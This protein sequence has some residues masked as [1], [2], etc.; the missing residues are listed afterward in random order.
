MGRTEQYIRWFGIPILALIITFLVKHDAEQAFGEKYLITLLFTFIFWN[1]S[2][3]TFLGFRRRFPEFR[4]T[5]Q[6][7]S[8]TIV[9]LLFV[10][11]I[12][13]N[14]IRLIFRLT[15]YE[16]YAQD[17]AIFFEKMGVSILAVLIIGSFYESAFFFDKW[18]QSIQANEA[19]KHQQERIQFEVL[20]NQMS[21]HFLF[22]SLNTLSQ[23]ISE[24]QALASEFS[25]KLSDV[26]RYILQNK[27]KELVPLGVELSFVKDYIYLMKMR[28]PENLFVN[29]SVEAV[30]Y[31]FSIAP[32]TLQILIENAVKH[33]V[34]SRAKPL[35][36]DVYTEN[37]KTILVKNNL[38]LKNK[39][40][41]S[42]QTGL[43]NIKKRYEY[44]G[45]E[46]VDVIVTQENFLVAIPLI[47]VEIGSLAMN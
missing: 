32:L 33:N 21:P 47:Q 15:T 26:Y 39:V 22:N 3:L 10:I 34:T 8:F 6:R 18:K 23:L 9:S 41:K 44:L 4:Q 29:F 5:P 2:Y 7:L 42:T 37:G 25:T 11:L 31:N 36:I 17:P 45:T 30:Y 27:T 16:E 13:Q 19:L 38:Q 28:Y 43:A 24:D 12:G 35:H 1:L 14:L 46:A 40:E 20:Q